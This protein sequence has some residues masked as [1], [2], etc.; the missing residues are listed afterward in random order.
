VALGRQLPVLVE[1]LAELAE[2]VRRQRDDIVEQLELDALRPL[3]LDLD[4]ELRGESVVRKTEGGREQTKQL[5]IGGVEIP[6]EWEDRP[7]DRM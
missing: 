6:V 1:A 3:P 4:V 2:V 7:T 5:D